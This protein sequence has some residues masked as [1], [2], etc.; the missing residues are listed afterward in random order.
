MNSE[1]LSHRTTTTT[2]E[3]NSAIITCKHSRESWKPT[4]V[5]APQQVPE[6]RDCYATISIAPK[7]LE[8]QQQSKHHQ[9]PGFGFL[10]FGGRESRATFW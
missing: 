10:P 3:L 7:V 2:F 8:Q 5:H 4:M 1:K 6:L 9:K